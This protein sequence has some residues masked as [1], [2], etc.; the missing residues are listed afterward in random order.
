MM[1]AYESI[2]WSYLRPIMEKLGFAPPCI[3]IVADMVSSISLSVVFNGNMLEEL[4]PTRG[5]R[6][7]DP[8]SPYLF[9]LAAEGLSCLLKSQNKS[10]HLSGVK[11]DT[12]APPVN[13]L[14]FADYSLLFFRAI[15]NGPK[16]LSNYWILTVWHLDRG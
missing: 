2:K 4:K 12:S 16:E 14:L 1:K 11:V 13:R 7:G 5:I 15:V 6:H 8:I 9:L 10:S 3:S